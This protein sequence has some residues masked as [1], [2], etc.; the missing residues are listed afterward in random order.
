MASVASV[1]NFKPDTCVWI[2]LSEHWRTKE[3]ASLQSLMHSMRWSVGSIL[4]ERF[5]LLLISAGKCPGSILQTSPVMQSAEG[6]RDC[7]GSQDKRCCKMISFVKIHS[8]DMERG[9][10]RWGRDSVTIT[11]QFSLHGIL[12]LP[13]T[14]LSGWSS[15]VAVNC[16][17][18]RTGRHWKHQQCK[19]Y[20][21][22]RIYS[23]NKRSSVST[24]PRIRPD[25]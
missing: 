16:W 21:N 22:F 9:D 3:L 4:L 10:G 23:T 1:V 7:N 25:I 15:C 6:H 5:V 12:S 20:N 19:G 17:L 13:Y 18:D 14:V 2:P 24:I 8:D 11:K